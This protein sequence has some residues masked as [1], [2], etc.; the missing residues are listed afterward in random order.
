MKQETGWRWDESYDGTTTNI[1]V[2]LTPLAGETVRFVLTVRDNGN[3][4]GDY[5]I[6]FMPQIW[7]GG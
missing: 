5:A 2:D 3:P 7:R 1:A 6:W 4:L